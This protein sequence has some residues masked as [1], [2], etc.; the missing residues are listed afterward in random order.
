MSF[1]HR[2]RL[3]AHLPGH[4]AAEIADGSMDI[5]LPG[6]NKQYAKVEN[7]FPS[8]GQFAVLSSEFASLSASFCVG[9][10]SLAAFLGRSRSYW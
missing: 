2:L 4:H 10:S 5:D 8:L 9:A 7:S 1:P 6:S 3:P